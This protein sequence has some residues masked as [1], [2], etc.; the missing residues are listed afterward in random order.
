MHLTHK[1]RYVD[2]DAC[3]GCGD[4]AEVCPVTSP[5]PYQEGLVHRKAVH[6]LYAQAI[7]GAYAVEKFD[8]APCSE[9]CP[10]G[11]N[12]QG[13]VQMVKEGKYREAV[14]II[15]RDLPLP[16][17]LGRVCP[18]PCE[19]SC[20]RLELDEAIA[21]RELK[22]EAADRVDLE[23]I[24]VPDIP[25]RVERVAI[26]GSGPA[27]LSA[28][29]VLALKGYG[30]DIYEAMPEP[31][32][33]LRYGIPSYRLP[34]DV[35]ERE[36]SNLTR[37][38]IEI[39]TD[40]PVGSAV[41]L[42]ELHENGADAVFLASG[43]WKGLRLAIPGEEA[44]GVREVTSFL[45]E[46]QLGTQ[47]SI[48]GTALVI[49]GGHS[50]VDGARTAL[51]LGAGAVHLVYRRSAGEMP[52]ERAEVVE[53]EK[54]GVRIH[55]LSAPIS[56]DHREG[57][58]QGLH[59]IRTRL[60]EP[61]TTGRRKPIP[62]EGSD[63]FIEADH[64]FT[65]IGQ[66]PDLSFLG[67]ESGLD[68]SRWNLVEV[69]PQT[70]Q[71]SVP[72]VFAGGDVVSGPATV[73]E[74]VEAGKRAASSMALFLEGAELPE[75]WID[76]PAVGMNWAPIRDNVP[77]HNRP[78]VSSLPLE[79]RTSGFEEVNLPLGDDALH[80]EAER[81]LNCGGCCDCFQCV[82]VCKAGA[83]TLETHAE[84]ERSSTVD[85]GAVILAPG[86]EA[87]DPSHIDTF[88]YKIYPDV[89]TSMEFERMLSATGPTEGHLA[90]PSDGKE[91]RS[92]AFVQ[93]VGSRDTD[94]CAHNYCS[95]V[96]CMYAVKEAIIARE[97]G[98]EEL[99][100]ALFFMDM[101]THGKE[102]DRY[103]DRAREQGVR[104][105]RSR[106]H[107]IE[108]GGGDSS[109]LVV[110]YVDEKGGMH[111][112]HFDMA[113]LSVGLE[114]SKE[115]RAVAGVLGIGLDEDGFAA[116]GSFTPVAG[117]R[118]GIFVC[119]A[120]SGP[121]D[122][123]QAVMEASGAAAGAAAILTDSRNTLVEEEVY[124]P[125]SS[126]A[127]QEPRIG[128]FVCHCGIN[129]GAVVDVPAVRDYVRSLPGVVYAG[130]NLFTC[131]QDTQEVI[132]DAVRE[133]RLNRVVVA[134]CTPRTHEPLFQ[135]T[136]RKAGLNKYLFEF[137]NIRDQDAW[138][139]RQEP[140]A[141]TEKAKD[142]V[143][144]AVAKV[145]LAEPIEPLKVDVTRAALIVGGGIAGMNA[146]LNLADRGYKTSL[147]ERGPSLGGQ[148]AGIRRTWKGE[149][150]V[151]YL[152][153]LVERV[154]CHENI[155]VFTGT[156][157][158]EVEGFVGNFTTT[159]DTG[160]EARTVSH[161]VAILA[162]GASPLAVT[163]YCYG[164]T[165]RVTSWHELETLFENEPSRLQETKTVAFI[166]CVGSREPGRRYCSRM[167]CTASVGQAVE[168][169]RRKPDLDVYVLYRDMRTFGQ[170]ESLYKE[171]RNLG[172]IFIR[173]T[174][175]DKPR[176]EVVR[177]DRGESIKIRVKDHILGIPLEIDADYLNLAT[178]VVPN[179]N[180]ELA[181]LFKVPLTSDG[182]FLEA[183]AKLRPVDF[184]SDGVFVAGMAQYP[185]PL[186]ESIAQ[187]LA[188]AGRAAGVLD[189]PYVEVEPIV[190][191][192]NREACVGCGFCERSCPYGAV[193]LVK[194]PG[195]G[196]RA[197]NLPALCKGCGVCAAGCP[198]KAID[199]RH[200]RDSQLSAAIQAGGAPA[201]EAKGVSG[202]KRSPA[203]A[204]VHG[205]T[206]AD[207][208][209][210][211]T[212]HCWVRRERGGRFTVGVND[213]M[214][215][216]LGP[217]GA[218]ELPRR[219]SVLHQG[220][221]GWELRR[222]GNSA[223]FLS[224][225]TGKVFHVNERVLSRPELLLEGPYGEGWVLVV[226]PTTPDAD[227]ARLL[228]GRP[229][230]EWLDGEYKKLLELL[231]P[232]YERLAAT[233][234]EA[235]SDIFGRFPEIGWG[236]LVETFLTA[237]A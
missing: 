157:L 82:S 127:E 170:R 92:I 75:E 155:E 15:M 137:A 7:P 30:V 36:I 13:Y 182:F 102:F 117:S 3:T 71:T 166:Q 152:A 232:D 178:A 22:R 101:R 60:T 49:G 38:G 211:H 187:A 213:F 100:T 233:G 173:Y 231:G 141:A 34:K 124:P 79:S 221:A 55:Y 51:R 164:Q 235:V 146:A 194:Q 143:R 171:A 89:V 237:D 93:C 208:Y 62:V 97:H 23:D 158:R 227:L 190:S 138:V 121:K 153:G 113:V 150:V 52:A 186:E 61:D 25:R 28:A 103:Y 185:K 136:I 21:I 108:K 144:M 195:E 5:D 196:F 6:K 78:A 133:H 24:P 90:R 81:C 165:E 110:R 179:D 48:G 77:R 142:L 53:A 192:V 107:T 205:F 84:K 4:C 35:L 183:H 99:D 189:R 69:N 91:P 54:E 214:A 200:F 147:V 123:P 176:V 63:F 37:Y 59:C 128:V 115:T 220:R 154:T 215:R 31:G 210:Y 132:R 151:D 96:C 201:L 64:I 217:A 44:E 70:L 27:G 8:R 130:D 191:V 204:M 65:A 95:S 156:T 122:I 9:A 197:E 45:R 72:W 167:C 140:E 218:L 73:I 184:A 222:N 125:E 223:P 83:I 229:V 177:G 14:E 148:G 202:R 19:K 160:G 118:P 106:I 168:L 58:V 46:V 126:V 1:P 203:P 135:E 209:L 16:G 39:H 216:V 29:Y 85:V 134:A 41:T 32:G 40:S 111:S 98:G 67:T 206:V 219:G 163:E 162:T 80:E 212:G 68:I 56:I 119:G 181:R 12:V 17:V 199:M 224:P 228:T 11:V 47:G 18:H 50:A 198:Q 66:E 236:R 116:T 159:V 188:A 87:F 169:K 26:V 94:S 42:R 131:S 76:E 230:E 86:F 74:A 193:R 226:E 129:I 145:A 172:V 105:L 180:E 43:A 207:D 104:F 120:V 149:S 114:T 57:R 225:L 109:D 20:R 175:D 174:L 10:A 234:G 112:E 88:G 2:V 139:H 33:M 161:G